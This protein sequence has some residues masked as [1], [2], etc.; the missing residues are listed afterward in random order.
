MGRETTVETSYYKESIN[1]KADKT[2]LSRAF[3]YLFRRSFKALEKGGTIQINTSFE[4][5]LFTNGG[6]CISLCDFQT[7]ADENDLEKI[8]DPLSVR[9]NG[10]IS[11][12]LP[13]CRKIIEDHGGSI[14]AL[15]RKNKN[16]EFEV[17]L[18]VFSGGG[19]DVE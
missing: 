4:K 14:K 8:F 12:E 1:V 7:T 11:L 15:R 9:L 3:S 5:N 19:E 10:Y 6:V 13:V 18:P 17:L 16:L 2:L